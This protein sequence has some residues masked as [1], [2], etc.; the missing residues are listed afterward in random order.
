ME[1]QYLF[2]YDKVKT[3]YYIIIVCM[4]CF[5][6]FSITKRHSSSM[7]HWLS[8]RFELGFAFKCNCVFIER[9][10]LSIYVTLLLD[11]YRIALLYNGT[12]YELKNTTNQKY[13]V[14]KQ[15]SIN[16]TVYT[17]LMY[18]NNRLMH[19]AHHYYL[20]IQVLCF[21]DQIGIWLIGVQY[22]VLKTSVLMYNI[23]LK[24]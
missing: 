8:G 20:L 17:R 12:R 11:I 16:S 13:L 10:S 7:L 15:I 22:S 23:V 24:E 14:T 3:V 19:Y 1:S 9:S 6:Q 4:L 21:I 5:P 18:T 2:D